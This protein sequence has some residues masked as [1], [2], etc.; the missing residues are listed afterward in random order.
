MPMRGPAAKDVDDY[1][2]SAPPEARPRLE[3]LRATIRAAAPGATEA[4][5]YA[6]PTFVLDGR[7]LVHFAAFKGHVGFYPTPSGL[8]AFA[9]ELARYETG[10]GTARFAHDEPIPYGLVT[11]IVKYRVALERERLASR[12][13]R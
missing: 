13:K 9:D 10:K 8:E 7:T 5:K 2:A 6:I 12:A 3:K 1:I 4:I 11:K